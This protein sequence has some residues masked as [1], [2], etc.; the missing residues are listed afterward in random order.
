VAAVATFVGWLLAGGGANAAL[1]SAVAVLI[2][3]CPCALGLATPMALLV[4]TGRGATLGI[5]IRGPQI[6]ETTRRVDTI[7]LDKTGTVTTGRLAL[8]AVV[9]APGEQ[10]AEVLRL[11][12]GLESGS[13]HPIARAVVGAAESQFDR[14][15]PVDGFANAQ[16]LGVRGQVDGLAAAVGRPGFLAELGMPLPAELTGDHRRAEAAGR[17]VVAVGW[18][19]RARG[20]LVV[21]D[22]VRQ[23]SPTAVRELR[24]LGL[25]PILL[26]G[27]N[28]HA[29]RAVAAAVGIDEVIAGVLPAQKAT[30]IR[31][32]Q[33][34]GSSVAMVGDGV[35]DAAALACADLGL[36]VGTGTDAAIEAA[37]LTLVRDDPRAIAD[38]IRLARRTLATIRGNLF[39]AFAYNVVAL[40]LAATGQLNPMIAGATMALSSVFVVSNSLRLRQFT[41]TREVTGA[42]QPE[43]LHRVERMQRDL[44]TSARGHTAVDQRT[45]HRRP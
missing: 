5:V 32:L 43:V 12:A 23:S 24:R 36:A 28:E 19:G 7:V 30:V 16:G 33:R 4:G 35:N 39:W 34:R 2:V 21:A 27:D 3:A 41:P 20:L 22:R 25:R 44:L 18:E 10:P 40:P 13:E 17:S 26:T 15:P 8:V 1:T 11:A 45:R 6:L 38:A 37:D 14:L 42:G 9:P 31:E 29:A